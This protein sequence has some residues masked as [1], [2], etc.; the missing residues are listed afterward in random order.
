MKKNLSGLLIL[1]LMVMT[2][3][4]K[5]KPLLKLWY[6]APAK[7]WMTEALP[8]GNGYLGAMIFGGTAVEE[9]QFNEETLWEG[10]PNPETGY[11]IGIRE[12]AWQ[13][14]PVIRQLLDAGRIEEADQLAKRELTGIINPVEHQDFGDFGS[15]QNFG[16]LKI[17]TQQEGAINNY[18]RDLNLS[19]AT[20][21]VTYQSGK[22]THKRIGFASYPRRTLVFH[23]SNDA[24]KGVKYQLSL[25]I[26]HQNIQQSFANNQLVASG[27]VRLNRL[28]LEARLKLDTD[29]KASFSNDT[30]TIEGARKVTLYL[31]AA[32]DYA[33]QYPNYRGE[34]P[35]V[36]I[37]QTMA[38]LNG[39]EYNTLLKE[40]L[41]D[42]HAL[43]NRVEID[44]GQSDTQAAAKTTAQRL[45][46]YA[47][48][49]R[50]P[51]L[52][53]LYFQAARYYMISSSR[54]GSMPATLQGKWNNSNRPP[55]ACD[56][57]TN[58][59]LQMIYWTCEV[60]NL[61]E[62]H[63]PLIDY[64][65]TLQQPG[66]KTT[67]AFFGVPGWTV[68]TM[69]NAFGYTAPGWGLPWGFFPAGSAWL[70]RHIWEHYEYTHDKELLK[71]MLPTMTEAVRFWHHYLQPDG[72][73]FLCSSP[74][75][76]PEH[77]EISSGATMDH[78]IVWDLYT[79]YLK[80]C[81]TLGINNDF[82][83]KTAR[84]LNRLYPL[85]IGRWGQLQEWKEDVDDPQSKHR[86]VSHLY[87]LYPGH[88]ITPDGTPELAQ[89]AVKTLDAR[90]DGGTG[91]SLAWKINFRARLGDGNHAHKMLQNLLKPVGS[92]GNDFDNSGGTYANLFCAHPP[93]QLDGNMGGA[94]GMAE[95]LLQSHGEK[96]VLLPALP[97]AWAN[98]SVKGLKARGNITVDLS[99]KNGKLDKVTFSS[100]EATILR[101]QYGSATKE[102]KTKANKP[103]ALSGKALLK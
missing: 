48:G 43:F 80:A 67:Q 13:H 93:F 94:A 15:F 24:P 46:D 76:S 92:S 52:E 51:E 90:G 102:L 66:E 49:S 22:T 68:N 96:I 8:I 77:G 101:F 5:N 38:G 3:A 26:P 42:Y 86:H 44:L 54:P 100:Q 103:I 97:D 1:L 11:N 35:A 57:H 39:K 18:Y 60:A 73:G 14:L 89:A 55:W 75:Y 79:N 59:N 63:S 47:H 31:T 19:D 71:A 98:G 32:T 36:K 10:G 27:L 84:D 82:T 65:K 33:N 95:M 61:P 62:C 91:W 2:A 72:E 17:T 34:A 83:Q 81:N 7:D 87:A 69:N 37:Q 50:D 20:A 58:I 70:C 28:N 64:I 16:S 85:K 74:S 40:H 6:D 99:W 29:G 9:I 88:Q 23:I 12:N 30:L 78:Q 45:Q 4:A 21:T 53:A 25:Q 41:A 56:Y